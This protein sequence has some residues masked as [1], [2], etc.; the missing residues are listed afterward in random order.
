MYLCAVYTH[1]QDLS[2]VG[3]LTYGHNII[4]LLVDVTV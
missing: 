2:D 3:S 1:F 4:H